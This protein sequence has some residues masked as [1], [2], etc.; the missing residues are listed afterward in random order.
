MADEVL[1]AEVVRPQAG[2]EVGWRA[3]LNFVVHVIVGTLL[4]SLI[5]L[6]AV[7]LAWLNAWVGSL[8]FGQQYSSLTRPHL[9]P[10]LGRLSDL[11][12]AAGNLYSKPH[13]D[14]LDDR[15]CYLR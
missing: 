14:L 4:F 5:A 13:Y 7:G 15:L 1:A 3:L 10:G 12:F 2:D 8:K 6:A 11:A 9:C